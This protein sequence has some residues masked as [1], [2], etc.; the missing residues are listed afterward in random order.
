MT[1]SQDIHWL[2]AALPDL[3][4]YLLSNEIFWNLGF[5]PQLTLGNL[6]LAEAQVKAASDLPAA[7]DR[8]RGNLLA[9][10]EKQKKEWNT[11]WKNK[12]EKEFNSRMR[13]WTNYLQELSEDPAR[14]GSHYKTEARVR[15]LLELLSDEAPGKKGDLKQLDQRLKAFITD[16][17]FIWGEESL[18]AFPKSKYWF[19]YARPRGN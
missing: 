7:E 17:D 5:D 16:G 10:L 3:K 13:Q 9:D 14:H 8:E 19:L 18:A 12:A 6:L 11:A 15:T 4:A 1:Y 2:R